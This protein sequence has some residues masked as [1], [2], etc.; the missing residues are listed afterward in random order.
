MTGNGEWVDGYRKAVAD[1]LGAKGNFVRL[2]A[3]QQQFSWDVEG[4]YADSRVVYGWLD[5]D[6]H[7]RR[8][9][10][11]EWDLESLRERSLSLFEG[12]F[13]DN[14]TEVGMEMRATC[15]CGLYENKWVRWVGSFAEGLEHVLKGSNG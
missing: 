12:T 15:N 9:G 6:D 5:W 3:Y 8:C 4:D 1:L 7:M 10:V 13:V 11:K 14:S 2:E